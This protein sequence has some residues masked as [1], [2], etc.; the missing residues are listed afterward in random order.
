MGVATSDDAA[1]ILVVEDDEL[2]SEVLAEALQGSYRA[3]SVGSAAAALE[4][5]GDRRYDLILLDCLIP[6][7]G[8]ELVIEQAGRLGIPLVLMS[9]AAGRAA[10]ASAG[11]HRFITKP[12]SIEELLRTVETTLQPG[13]QCPY[14]I[15]SAVKL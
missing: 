1:S 8:V 4:R 7:G 15:D 6:G 3:A 10:A 14:V 13:C 9:G 5:L 12:F 2:V 11:R